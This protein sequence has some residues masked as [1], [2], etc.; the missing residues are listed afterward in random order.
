VESGIKKRTLVN[1]IPSCLF[2]ANPSGNIQS[3]THVSDCI[4]YGVSYSSPPFPSDRDQK[5]R[6][7]RSITHPLRA[8]IPYSRLHLHCQAETFPCKYRHEHKSSYGTLFF[9]C[10]GSLGPRSLIAHKFNKKPTMRSSLLLL[11]SS[12]SP[13]ETFDFD[14]PR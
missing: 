5:S 2:W 9:H 8:T 12:P 6:W 7:N 14:F 10:M 4:A 1:T 13:A 3:N 11:G